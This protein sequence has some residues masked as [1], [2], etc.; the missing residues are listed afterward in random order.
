MADV[1]VCSVDGC[2]KPRHAKGLCS[3]HNSRRVR[4]GSP[5]GGGPDKQR[6]RGAKC[7][8][9]G[10]GEVARTKGLCGKHYQRFFK[11]GDPL[12]CKNPVGV[13]PE[14]CTVPGCDAQHHANGFCARHAFRFKK[15]GDPLAGGPSLPTKAQVRG[16][17]NEAVAH[18]GNG[19]FFW[20]FGKTDYPTVVWDGE[21]IGA[22]RLVCRLAHGE[23]PKPRMVAAHSCGNGHLGCASAKHLRWATYKENEADKLLHGTRM[24]GGKCHAAKLTEQDV[25][26]IRAMRGKAT[27]AQIGAMF[28]ISQPL[29]S[30]V[31]IRKSWAWLD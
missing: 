14:N 6:Y 17:L 13:R 7:S 21:A 18:D 3:S 15:Y 11:Y 5:I 24:R 12:I 26:S 10:C 4:Y 23:P 16:A 1:K 8:V 31:Q 28:G 19:C 2:G 25:R 30:A 9:E 29:V 27:Q 20:P 22:H